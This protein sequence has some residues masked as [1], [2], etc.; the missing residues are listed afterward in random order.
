MKKILLIVIVSLCAYD[1]FSQDIT[2]NGFTDTRLGLRLY[3]NQK[4]EPYL[5]TSICFPRRTFSP[6]SWKIQPSAYVTARYGFDH[7][8]KNDNTVALFIGGYFG[9]DKLYLTMQ[10]G[11]QW[12]FDGGENGNRDWCPAEITFGGKYTLFKK[13]KG[14]YVTDAQYGVT[15]NYDMTHLLGGPKQSDFVR[16]YSE[17]NVN[18]IKFLSIG[19]A[20][21]FYKETSHKQ[22][23]TNG[24]RAIIPIQSNS[25]HGLLVTLMYKSLYF[26]FWKTTGSD[27]ACM[28]TLG[29]H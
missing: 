2:K 13:V 15:L 24:R 27:Q 21:Q 28:T 10:T 18:I 19:Y 6:C 29:V 1:A 20:G 11:L 9:Q 17:I 26:K 5:T 14:S 25:H 22:V 3:P 8:S 7:P 23:V 12:S 4:Q 16:N